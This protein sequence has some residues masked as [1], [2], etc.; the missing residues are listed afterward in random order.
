[1]LS[2]HPL[3]Q[4]GQLFPFYHGFSCIFQDLE[5]LTSKDR[6]PW[7]PAA[8]S[9]YSMFH[10]LG[11]R[12]LWHV[13]NFWEEYTVPDVLS[14]TSFIIFLV[15]KIEVNLTLNIKHKCKRTKDQPPPKLILA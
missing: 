9:L 5:E 12:I 7:F 13:G 11:H 3:S 1:M 14:K 10:V 6:Q 15:D 2:D 8:L 4:N